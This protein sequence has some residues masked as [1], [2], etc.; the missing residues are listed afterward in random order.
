MMKKCVSPD[1]GKLLH[2]Y[3]LRKLSA[4][5]NERF[6]I[7]LLECD[8]CFKE[9]NDF[10]KVSSVMVSGKKIRVAV[11][12]A[13]GDTPAA[14][15]LL[16][17]ILDYLWPNTRLVLKPA[18]SYLIIAFLIYP[19]YLGLKTIDENQ[20]RSVQVLNLIPERS[21][22]KPVKAGHDILLSF[23]FAEAQPGKSYRI[24]IKSNDRDIIFQDDNFSDFDEFG[25]ASLL[26]PAK[27]M[28]PGNYSLIIVDP[29]GVPPLNKQEYSF[30][31][32]K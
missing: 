32:E 23:A 27:K 22:V 20:I 17:K 4:E 18:L 2:A 1:V 30:K 24:T 9:V 14:E 15:S 25:I 16:S 3:E 28:K 13:V 5:D 26:L 10:E 12:E 31:I 6:E 19:A 8:H 21:I 7:H 29:E 11:R